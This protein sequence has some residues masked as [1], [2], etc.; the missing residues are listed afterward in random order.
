MS[1][2]CFQEGNFQPLWEV[3]G[4]EQHTSWKVRVPDFFFEKMSEHDTYMFLFVYLFIYLYL[5]LFLYLCVSFSLLFLYPL[6][7]SLSLCLSPCV[8]CCRRGR[9]CGG[10]GGRGGRWRREETN[11]TISPVVSLRSFL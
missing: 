6:S 10:G 8:V 4:L 5:Y 1:T 3:K 9:G 2:L 11:R 7:L